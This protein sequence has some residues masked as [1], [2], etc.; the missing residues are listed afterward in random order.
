EVTSLPIETFLENQGVTDTSN[1]VFIVEFDD[2]DLQYS[3]VTG[4]GMP[5]YW[6]ASGT[7]P[8][9]MYIDVDDDGMPEYVVRDQN[10]N[11]PMTRDNQ[12][13]AHMAKINQSLDVY[14][15]PEQDGDSPVGSTGGN[16]Y[17]AT[18]GQSFTEGEIRAPI[19]DTID[20]DNQLIMDA[21]IVCFARG[22]LILT[23]TGERKIE[24]LKVGDLVETLDHGAQP[25][26]WIS[27]R[28]IGKSTLIRRESLR[29]VCITAGALGKGYPRRDLIVSPQHRIALSSP[30]IRRMFDQNEVLV[31]AK[32]LVGHAGITV[33]ETHEVEYFH[34]MLDRH[35]MVWAN[36]ALTE[37]M[38]AGPMALRALGPRQCDEIKLIFP[39]LDMPGTIPSPARRVTR[40]RETRKLLKRHVKNRKQLFDE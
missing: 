35:E 11:S 39:E 34:F 19:D 6:V 36:G 9:A 22:T 31:P 1:A 27:S 2:T 16:L 15:Y 14:T 13:G 32:H 7:Q 5:E 18:D 38:L 21:A 40:Q 10:N 28:S 33:Q 25:I 3:D 24:D 23:P 29:P 26:R 8:T 17:F 12:S 37:T 4:D 30:I 20:P